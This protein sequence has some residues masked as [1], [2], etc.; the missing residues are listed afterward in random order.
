MEQ[1]Q[2]LKKYAQSLRK[3]QTKE[4][5][6]LWYQFLSRYPCRFRRQYIIGN[7]IADFYCHKARLV[8]ELDGSQ[9][10][11]P[12]GMENDHKR[13]EFMESLGIKVLRF[14]NLEILREFRNVC[15]MIDMAVK[16]RTDTY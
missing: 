5:A 13:T 16:E 7:Y 11:D 12:L 9:H 6:L 10:F 3:S 2:N 14:T 4:E 8:V 1:N 15:E